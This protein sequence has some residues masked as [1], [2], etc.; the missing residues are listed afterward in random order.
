MYPRAAR[1]NEVSPTSQGDRSARRVRVEETPRSQASDLATTTRRGRPLQG[2]RLE[3]QA[4]PHPRGD[5]HPGSARGDAPPEATK[6]QNGKRRN[7]RL[8]GP[9]IWTPD[10]SKYLDSRPAQYLDSR[11]FVHVHHQNRSCH[12]DR[13]RTGSDSLGRIGPAPISIG[14]TSSAAPP[15]SSR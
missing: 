6:K 2:S 15:P 10:R 14:A 4:T 7:G 9:N 8:T 13:P 12:F 5:L 1:G 11:D 3:A